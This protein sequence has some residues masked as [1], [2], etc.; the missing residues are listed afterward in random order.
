MT[1][2]LSTGDLAK[3]IAARKAFLKR[4]IKFVL[5]IT[6]ERGRLVGTANARHVR[7]LNRHCNFSFLVDTSHEK[8][9]GN[10]S[11]WYYPGRDH[12]NTDDKV[13]EL[14]W[15]TKPD[16]CV[17][18]VFDQKVLWQ[19]A[20]LELIKNRKKIAREMDKKSEGE[21][22]ERVARKRERQLRMR[23]EGEARQLGL[24]MVLS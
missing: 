5:S 17:V 2:T 20:L 24:N 13:L 21:N 16:E 23:L 10:V 14:S 12:P 9:G 22:V 11:I 19:P 3:A 15:L 6:E 7:V 18:S 4:V 1:C 8:F